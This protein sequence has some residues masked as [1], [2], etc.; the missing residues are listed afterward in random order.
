MYVKIRDGR[1]ERY[2]YTF[3]DLKIDNPNVSFNKDTPLEILAYYG[4]YLVQHEKT[5]VFNSLTHRVQVSNI[6]KLVNNEWVLIKELVELDDS[7]K[8]HKIRELET[9]AKEQRNKLLAATDW[10][11]LT[12]NTMSPEMA[13]Y[14]QELRNISKQKGFPVNIV[15]PEKPE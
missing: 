2:P 13:A 3:D 9:K 7:E 1:V 15:W 10:L 11:A 14:R 6:P 12:D 8:E 5:P 4:V